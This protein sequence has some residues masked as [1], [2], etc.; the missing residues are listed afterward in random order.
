MKRKS[1][2]D[3]D[4]AF[5]EI[6]KNYEKLLRKNK[7]TLANA[8]ITPIHEKFPLSQNGICALIAPMGS[9]KSFTTTKMMCQQEVLFNEPFFELICICSTSNKFDETVNTFKG[10][11]KKSKLVCIK[12]SDLLDWLNK[13]IRRILKY[14]SIMK[15]LNSNCK[16]SNEEV[17]RL[18]LKHRLQ[19]PEKKLEYIASKLAQYQW[20]TFPHRCLL[21]LDDWAAHPLLRSK[22]TEMSRLL[23]KLRHFNINVMICVQTCKS[24]S[25]D[26]R[27]CLSDI[28]LFPGVNEQDFIDL[29][30]ETPAG[31][32]DRKQLWSAYH[33]IKDPH[34]TFSIYIKA[35]KVIINQKKTIQK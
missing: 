25:K 9:G 34:A 15:Y 31:A 5:A 20:S 2:Q 8:Q 35:N 1:I 33:A 3:V 27:R 12:D 24:L 7:E 17:D 22:E 28:I 18:F 6:D 10:L 13:Y 32:F 11:I 19:K 23:K 16:Q 26:I 29:I 21:I 30:K 14:N 4:K